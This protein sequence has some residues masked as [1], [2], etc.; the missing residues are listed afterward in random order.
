MHEGTFP[1]EG[2]PAIDAQL[3]EVPGLAGLRF[4][5]VAGLSAETAGKLLVF[6]PELNANE[7]LVLMTN[8]LVGTMRTAE[9]ERLLTEGTTP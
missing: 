9:I 8:G 3:W 2:D 1:S 5:Y 4:Q 7:R 6:E